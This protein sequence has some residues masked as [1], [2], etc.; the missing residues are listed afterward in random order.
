MFG[1]S[2]ISQIVNRYNYNFS[3]VI[4]RH[5]L[6]NINDYSTESIRSFEQ[7]IND[8]RLI[9]TSEEQTIASFLQM[10]WSINPDNTLQF[11]KDNYIIGLSILVNSE[12]FSRALGLNKHILITD[13][14]HNGNYNSS[15]LHWYVS[16]IKLL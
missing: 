1:S 12:C 8:C 6:I 16:L 11:L 13:L 15:S 5:Q 10:N 3:E 14:N 9:T 2:Y 4:K 7:L